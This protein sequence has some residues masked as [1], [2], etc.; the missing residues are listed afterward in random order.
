M[1]IDPLTAAGAI[2]LTAGALFSQLDSDRQA[3]SSSAASIPTREVAAEVAADAL[4]AEAE[5]AR[6]RYSS[7]LCLRS[8]VPL[9]KGM[10][11]DPSHASAIVCDSQGMTAEVAPSGKLTLFAR[12]GDAEAIAGGLRE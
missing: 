2:A 12:T 4:E 1:R 6:Q 3:I 7:G 11:L 10:E 9:V 5:L 8:T